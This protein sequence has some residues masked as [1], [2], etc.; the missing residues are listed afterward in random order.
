MITLLLKVL[1]IY[2]NRNSIKNEKCLIFFKNS[3]DTGNKQHKPY[4]KSF[5]NVR[6]VVKNK[7]ENSNS[8]KKRKEKHKHKLH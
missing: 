2:Y 4:R 1:E 6:E 7:I 3:K 8:D 5:L